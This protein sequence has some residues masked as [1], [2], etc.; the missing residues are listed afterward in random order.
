MS[1]IRKMFDEKPWFGWALFGIAMVAIFVL[2]I[3]AA[4]IME[5]RAEALIAYK[6]VEKIKDFEPRNE[7]WGKNFPKEYSSFLKTG[8]MNFESKYNGNKLKD[9]LADDPNLVVLWAGYGFSKDYNQPRGHIYAVK[10]IRN[11]LRTGGP[12]SDKDGPMP[13]TCWTCKS[14]DVPRV[15]NR[16]GIA[17]YYKGKWSRLGSEIVNPIGCGDCHDPDTMNLKITRPALI[18]AFQRQGIDITKATHQEKRSLVC[19]QCHVEYYFKGDGKYLTFP[20][21]KGMN[22]EDME[23]YYDSYNFSDWTHKLSKAPMIK[24]QHPGYETWKH[25]IH[26]KRGVS[27]ADCHM[28]YVT[29]GGVKSTDHHIQSPLNNINRSCQTCHRESEETLKNDVYAKQDR[30]HQLRMKAEKHLVRAH[31]EAKKAWDIGAKEAEMKNILMLIRHAQW[32]WDY[33]VAAHGASFHASLEISR[34]LGTA[35]EKA[36]EA[37]RELTKVLFNHGIKEE[38]SLPDLSTKAKAQAYI[39]LDMAKLNAEK[40][41]FKKNLIPQWDKAAKERQDKLDKE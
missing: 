35:I 26:A 27:C 24:A 34:I 6:P 23:A 33:A 12:T 15:M 8:E 32:R 2:G 39:G 37:R 16:D 22:V 11:T 1:K 36:I 30:V 9:M 7:V 4:S 5:R 13:S 20:W 14:P 17:E 25:G 21:D 28:P 18:E 40:E 38:V 29:E 31:I 10:D 3:F 41:A 19:A